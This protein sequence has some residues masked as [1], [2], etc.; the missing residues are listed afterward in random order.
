MRIRDTAYAPLLQAIVAAATVWAT[1]LSWSAFSQDAPSYLRPLLLVGLVVALTGSLARWARLPWGL[2]VLAQL[3]VGGAVVS[4]YITGSLVPIGGAW[5]ELRA[6]LSQAREVVRTQRPP[7]TVAGGIAPLL[8]GGGLLCFVIVDLLAC[9]FR[10]AALAGLPL[11]A[12]YAVPF[13]VVEGGLPW[14]GF[15][16]SAAGFLSMLVLSQSEIVGRWGRRLDSTRASGPQ[17]SAAA[18]YVGSVATVL[19]LILPSLVPT[20]D[21]H[22][23]GLGPGSGNGGRITVTNPLVDLRRDLVRGPDIPVIQVTTDDPNPSYLRIAVLN[24]FGENEWTAGNRTVPANNDAEGPMPG[25][26]GV[27][28]WVKRTTYDYRVEVGQRFDSRWLPTQAPISEIHAA[29]DWRFDTRTMDF[30]AGPHQGSAAG[31]NYRMTSV[32]LDLSTADLINA[33]ASPGT[34][35]SSYLDLPADFPASARTLAKNVTA[36]AVGDFAKA[37]ALQDWFRQDGG[38]VYDDTV[39]I[40]SSPGDLESFLSTAGGGRRGYCQQFAAAMAAMAR[41]LDIPARVA[42]GFLAPDKVGSGRWEYS[43]HDMH[44]WPELFFSGAGW[45][46]FEPTPAAHV[47]NVPSYTRNLDTAHPNN[48]P[49]LA[50]SSAQPNAQA[51]N[52]QRPQQENSSATGSGNATS[53]VVLWWTVGVLVVALV[54]G[55]LALVPSRV[56][57]RRRTTRLGAANAEAAWAEIRDTLV[58]LGL[59][60][61]PG[62]SPRAVGHMLERYVLGDDRA[63]LWRIVEAVEVSRYSLRPPVVVDPA[64]V[65]AVLAA[66]RD[67]VPERAVRRAD[68]WPRSVLQRTPVEPGTSEV[69]DEVSAETSIR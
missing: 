32:D 67:A 20:L 43:T 36:S 44:A 48:G 28:T 31:M 17:E 60:W 54:S 63:A 59:L 52:A 38:F 47:P 62:L 13:S 39:P 7:V 46:R 3:V 50:T 30:L 61:P 55:G 49:S 14:W 69:V 56:R 12:I 66:L 40:G 27:A 15:A 25:L 1:T 21:L 4:L 34:V 9:T 45:V 6:E 65:L 41:A 53:H 18:V 22:L 10:R 24:R 35:G 64:D 16:L 11:L 42:V 37:V 51:S 8:V 26:L 58:D 57:R 33:Q 29:G 19:A 23:F 5:D 2:I 68:W